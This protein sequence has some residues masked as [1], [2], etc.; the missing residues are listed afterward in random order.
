MPAARAAPPG[1]KIRAL[2]LSD[3]D[4]IL[5]IDET[6]T[7]VRRSGGDN[8]LWRLLAETTT[9]F[10]AEVDHRLAGFVLADARPWEFGTRSPVGW[11]I[12][13]G[14]DPSY[15]GQGVGRALGERVVEE[16]HR[17]GVSEI[18]TLVGD[19]DR[20]LRTYFQRLGFRPAQELVLR[21]GPTKG[22]Q[23]SKRPPRPPAA[24]RKRGSDQH[25]SRA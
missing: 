16:F 8:D 11:I 3:L 17:L 6:L 19:R 20:P 15:Q 21:I 10:G 12:A 24:R 5:Q 2:R 1:A 25:R 22:R 13:L 23:R 18:K 14:V 7:R 9:C 4:R